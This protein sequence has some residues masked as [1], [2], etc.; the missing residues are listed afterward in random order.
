MRIT[1]LITVCA[2]LSS[3]VSTDDI[4]YFTRLRRIRSPEEAF[5]DEVRAREKLNSNTRIYPDVFPILRKPRPQRQVETF[6]KP[7]PKKS[8]QQQQQPQQQQQY[9]R[10]HSRRPIKR[11]KVRSIAG[12]S[13]EVHDNEVHEL[14]HDS[15]PELH[16]EGSIYIKPVVRVTKKNIFDSIIDILSQLLD[17]PRKELGP[18]VG[19]I[20]MPGSKRKIYIRLMEP[21]DSSHINVR[22]VTQVPVPVV[23][24]ESILSKE[25]SVLPFLPFGD[26]GVTLL[27]KHHPHI[28]SSDVTFSSSNHHHS[29]QLPRNV[30]HVPGKVRVSQPK[31]V[32]KHSPSEDLKETEEIKEAVSPVKVEAPSEANK[33]HLYYQYPSEDE[34]V[35]E[36]TEII[37]GATKNEQGSKDT[38][39]PWYQLSTHRLPLR[40]IAPLYPLSA[41][42]HTESGSYENTYKVPSDSLTVPS[43][44]LSSYEQYGDVNPDA[45]GYYDQ[46]SYTIPNTYATTYPKQNEF[47][48]APSSYPV[49]YQ[50][51]NEFSNAPSP[52]SYVKQNDL[53]S[54]PTSHTSSYEKPANVPPPS[55]SYATSH[56]PQNGVQTASDTS[57]QNALRVI[58]PP[59]YYLDPPKGSEN[60][61]NKV[62]EHPAIQQQPYN[63]IPNANELGNSLVRNTA[64]NGQPP[65]DQIT[66]GKVKREKSESNFQKNELNFPTSKSNFQKSVEVNPSDDNPEKW[67]PLSFVSE[68][69]N[70]QNAFA[71]SAKVA[72]DNHDEIIARQQL[73][74]R[75]MQIPQTTTP[76]GTI[77]VG[78][79]NQRQ[80]SRRRNR[81]VASTRNSKC[82]P[83][84]KGDRCEQTEPTIVSTPHPEGAVK[85]MEG[86]AQSTA[87][88]ET[89]VITPKSMVSNTVEMSR[90]NVTT[91]KSSWIEPPQPLVMT[92]EATSTTERLPI[93]LKK[94]IK[95]TT[96]KSIENKTT[97]G[98]MSKITEKSAASSATERLSISSTKAPIPRNNTKKGLPKRPT[99]MKKP[100]FVLKKEVELSSTTTRRPVASNTMW[101]PTTSSTTEKTKATRR[102]K[103]QGAVSKM[104]SSTT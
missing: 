85:I 91:M 9:S 42:E 61:A 57:S 46:S 17:P 12:S 63:P 41:M 75:P 56:E 27:H 99:I 65:I 64:Q 81:P 83:S 35:K 89:I 15:P 47:S 104:K 10:D 52:T 19:P 92:T 18:I 82:S 103:F 49:S 43:P 50:N 53:F 34:A 38:L 72:N 55:G 33:N 87:N 102:S 66:W 95:N 74:N 70:W 29:V 80:T 24:E 68:N 8:Q 71:N 101:K 26:P 98:S 31:P 37:K 2:Y 76:E 13:Y 40:Q 23:D 1:C 20:K 86:Q 39:E 28:G 16:D 25:H 5:F 96:E 93:S 7:F 78:R 45:S 58:D 88:I 77:E 44:H 100:T 22:F 32:I 59:H 60:Q 36:V 67:Q 90:P 3:T 79:V 4:Q 62:F 21:V 94:V 54:A 6:Q 11:V 84:E 30:S 51:Q 48:N 73:N 14:I 69:A 97:S